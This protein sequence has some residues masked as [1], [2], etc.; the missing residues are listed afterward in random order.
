MHPPPATKI[1][2]GTSFTVSHT[3]PHIYRRQKG[4]VAISIK[5]EIAEY[6]AFNLRNERKTK[7]ETSFLEDCFVTELTCFAVLGGVDIAK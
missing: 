1:H 2:Q 3:H 6:V 7:N 5:N 4:D